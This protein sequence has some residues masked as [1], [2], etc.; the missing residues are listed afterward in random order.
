MNL[1]S[2]RG[3]PLEVKLNSRILKTDHCWIWTGSKDIHRYGRIGQGAN[4]YVKAHRV[5]YM[6]AYGPI[7]KGLCVLHRCDNPSCVRPDHL[8]LGTYA[9]NNKDRDLKQRTNIKYPDSVVQKAKQLRSE[10][11]TYRAIKIQLGIPITTQTL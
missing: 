7:P 10:G 6:I 3:A 8:F 5:S 1:K 11:Y 9:D 4:R 2:L